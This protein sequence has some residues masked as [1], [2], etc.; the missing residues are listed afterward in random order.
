MKNLSYLSFFLLLTLLLRC[1]RNCFDEPATAIYRLGPVL[2]SWMG[3]SSNISFDMIDSDSITE[4]WSPQYRD[5]GETKMTYQ[6]NSHPFRKYEKEYRTYIF[7]SSLTNLKL[8]VHM[9]VWEDIQDLVL[10]IGNFY[11]VYNPLSGKISG[12]QTPDGMINPTGSVLDSLIV[13]GKVWRQVLYIDANASFVSFPKIWFSKG[14][15][16]IQY[17]NNNGKTWQRIP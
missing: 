9:R 3:D 1:R 6:C 7:H 2:T 17:Q 10:E 5:A 4:T 16:V 13:Q 12:A 14:W 11:S 15:G 8:E